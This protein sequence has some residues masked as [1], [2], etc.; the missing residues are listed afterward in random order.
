MDLAIVKG[1]RAAYFKGMG[2]REWES[3]DACNKAAWMEI[4]QEMLTM[5]SNHPTFAP[6]TYEHSTYH[7]RGWGAMREYL[8]PWC[9]A[10]EQT[11][12]F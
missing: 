11:E 2:T 8:K 9:T 5:P 12:L 6:R 3:W 10:P 7:F 4:V 1:A